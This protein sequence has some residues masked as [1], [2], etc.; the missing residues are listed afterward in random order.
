MTMQSVPELGAR[1]LP[2]SDLK[3]LQGPEDDM[4]MLLRSILSTLQRLEWQIEQQSAHFGSTGYSIASGSSLPATN[5]ERWEFQN[6]NSIQ[7]CFPGKYRGTS[8]N[9]PA[10][11]PDSQITSPTEAYT[12]VISEL[13]RNF[14]F[15]DPDD[16]NAEKPIY[17]DKTVVERR[18]DSTDDSHRNSKEHIDSEEARIEH[19]GSVYSSQPL[20]SHLQLP[21]QASTHVVEGQTSISGFEA[22]KYNTNLASCHCTPAPSIMV[23]QKPTRNQRFARR[24]LNIRRDLSRH[25]THFSVKR[26]ARPSKKLLDLYKSKGMDITRKWFEWVQSKWRSQL[27]AIER[28]PRRLQEKLTVKRVF[29][30]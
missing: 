7:Q 2:K 28:A 26:N 12:S 22:S 1:Q 3:H 16:E 17:F 13:R 19:D 14:E 20:S 5:M 27:E 4:S 25:A 18:D 15:V 21:D 8:L 29:Y 24:L 6:T 10:T 23:P 30:Y 11:P 9:L